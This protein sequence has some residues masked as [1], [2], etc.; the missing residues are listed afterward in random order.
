MKYLKYTIFSLPLLFFVGSIWAVNTFDIPSPKY[1]QN[2]K[3]IRTVVTATTTKNL[4]ANFT[5]V[6][7]SEFTYQGVCKKVKDFDGD[8]YSYRTVSNGV[9]TWSTTS[10]E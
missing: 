4:P 1:K 9:V 2:P 7:D 3:A 5:Y 10:C 6:E 8:G